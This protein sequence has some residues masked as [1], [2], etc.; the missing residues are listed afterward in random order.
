MSI[1]SIDID[2]CATRNPCPREKPICVN[3]AGGYKCIKPH[4]SPPD[5]DEDEDAEPIEDNE[6]TNDQSEVVKPTVNKVEPPQKQSSLQ[7]PRLSPIL[8]RPCPP[9]Y[10]FN[11][12]KCADIDECLEGP[13]CQ[14]HERCS[15]RLGG[16]DC[17]LLCRTGWYFDR[18]SK[19]CQ[20]VDEC[21]LGRH[22]CSQITHVCANTNGSFS[23]LEVPPCS[24]GYRR[25]A[26]KSCTDV[27]ECADGLHN[28]RRQDHQYCVNNPGGFDCVTRLPEC[29]HG[30]QYSLV[31]RSCQDVDECNSPQGSPCDHRLMETCVNLKGSF[32]CQRPV[33]NTQRSRPACPPGFRYDIMRRQCEGILWR[34][35]GACY[36]SFVNAWFYV[37]VIL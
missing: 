3:G 6:V 17:R 5:E 18:A 37:I 32:R 25:A 8:R 10:R 16:Y 36:M 22:N 27:D 31:S 30:Y 29:D 21:L 20:D 14:E 12:V 34:W 13:G 1:Y 33:I 15:N 2:E 35:L 11:G 4:E 24:S 7:S 19:T 26:D 9:G 28:C 23:C